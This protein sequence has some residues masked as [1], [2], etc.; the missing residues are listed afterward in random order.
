LLLGPTVKYAFVDHILELEEGKRILAIKNISSTEDY[1]DE[2]YPRLGSVPGSLIIE[3]MAST[4]GLLLLASTN[5]ASLALLLMIEEA[6]FKNPVYSGDRMIVEAKLLSM[7]ADA[8][9]MEAAVRVEETAMACATL[10]LGLFEI[11][12]ISD[13]LMKAFFSSLLDRIRNWMQR[14][15]GRR[16]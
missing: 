4:A 14:S 12:T 13:P 3:S 16:A 6:Q 11:E 9:R 1:L 15:C 8:A 2:L 10:V 5:F 7:H